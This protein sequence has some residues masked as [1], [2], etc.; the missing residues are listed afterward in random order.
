MYEK[1]TPEEAG[2][3]S[4]A[5]K[6]YI[7]G[8][9]RHNLAMHAVL[10]MKGDKIFSESYWEPFGK[11]YCHRMYSVTKSFVSMGIGCLIDEGKLRLT[12]RVH[13]YFKDRYTRELPKYL[14]EQTVRDMLLMTTCGSSG[15]WFSSDDPDRTH[16]YF[17]NNKADHPS[18]SYWSYDSAG[19]Q[20]LCSLV[21]RLA[22]MPLLDYLKLKLFNK[23]GTFKTAEVLK[24][25]NGDSWGDSAL[26]CTARDLASA[27]LLMMRGG[28]WNGEQLISREYV[29][30]ACSALVDNR[31]GAHLTSFHEGYGYQIWRSEEDSFAFNGMGCQLLI[32]VPKKDF[33][34]VCNADN[35]GNTSAKDIITMPLFDL[36]VRPMADRALDADPEGLRALEEYNSGL[37][38]R[39]LD[40][41][42]DS[43]LREKINGVRFIAKE[44]DMGIKSFTFFFE[45][46]KGELRYTNEQGEKVLPF[47]INYNVFGKFPELG[48]ADEYGRVKTTNGF[49]YKDAVS[50]CFSDD[51]KILI[52]VQIIDRYFGN[53][54]LQ[55]N[56]KG[57]TCAARF[58]KNAE[59]FLDKYK[60]I[61]IAEKE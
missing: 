2:I 43:P 28:E 17:E 24:A 36:V 60:G 23:M 35:Q 34:F 57:D 20:V 51:N 1:I 25:P 33:I 5:V 54:S 8:L 44:N 55:F 6:E 18:G 3:S 26:I 22:G 53:A 48:Y 11:D 14:R 9:N 31:E 37:K 61:M 15:S 16:F 42:S 52:Y 27:G 38:L 45:G 7:E 40:G 13:E 4:L 49:M 19:S 46:D 56:F 59:H 30:E 50:A 21:E 39:A 58:T 47:G 12:D 32:C 29:E 10:M 41:L